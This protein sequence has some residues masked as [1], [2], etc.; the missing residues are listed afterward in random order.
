M[1]DTEPIFFWREKE[2]NGYLCQYYPAT[3]CNTDDPK[4]QQHEF[5]C[6]EQW[7]MYNKALI[8]A[9]PDPP[10]APKK[11][12]KGATKSAPAPFDEGRR[13]LPEMILAEKQPDKQKYMVQI[14]PFTKV[15]KKK[16]D[17]TKFQIVVAGN[18]YKFSQNPELKKLLMAT[19]ERELFEAAPNDRT[20]GI[21][22]KAEEAKRH[23]DRTSWGSNLL[24]NALMTVRE[25][26][27]AEEAEE[28]GDPNV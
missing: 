12:T 1:A 26:L 17:A 10:E 5:N 25:R 22:F 18:Y 15:G 16:Y 20:W 28:Q 6:A 3:F 11:P 21:G 24:G 19:G 2:S 4:E 23:T 9:T 14:V 13:K 27:R 8:L 7:M